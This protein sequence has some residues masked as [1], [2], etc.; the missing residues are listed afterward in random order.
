MS[1]VDVGN[2]DVTIGTHFASEMLHLSRIRLQQPQG[3]SRCHSRCSLHHHTSPEAVQTVLQLCSLSTATA[4]CPLW[5]RLWK[6]AVE[7]RTA[8]VLSDQ[9]SILRDDGVVLHGKKITF[10]DSPRLTLRH[11]VGVQGSSVAAECMS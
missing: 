10:Q 2:G 9:L 6:T 4:L 5:H 7:G 3:S 1:G 11:V 8:V